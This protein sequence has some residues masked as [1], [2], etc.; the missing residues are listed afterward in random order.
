MVEEEEMLEKQ[1]EKRVEDLAVE[2]QQL[3]QDLKLPDFKV[4]V[5]AQFGFL[6]CFHYTQP[7]QLQRDKLAD[8]LHVTRSK[9]MKLFS[10]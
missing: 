4:S 8:P 9:M 6:F 7:V 1:I 2:I 3:S 5:F 10:L